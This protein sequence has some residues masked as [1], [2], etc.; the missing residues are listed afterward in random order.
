L[1]AL[2]DAQLSHEIAQLLRDRGLDVAAVTARDDI[3]SSASDAKLMEIAAA[4]D[5]AVITNNIKDF[6]PIAARRLQSGQA[7]AGLILVP[8]SRRRTRAAN[9]ALAD[10][11]AAVM[12]ANPDGLADSER[13]LG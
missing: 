8:S 1:K 11:V 5:R 13:W 4:E 9:A 10:E 12:R 7:H 6:R 3:P 2:L